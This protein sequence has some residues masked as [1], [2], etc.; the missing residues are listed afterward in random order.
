MLSMPASRAGVASAVALLFLVATKRCSRPQTVL[1]QAPQH[2]LVFI[3]IIVA[4]DVVGG[5]GAA[6]VAAFV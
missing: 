4:A 5:G 2:H 3:V 6:A 1:T